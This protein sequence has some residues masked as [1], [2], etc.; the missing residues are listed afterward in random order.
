[1]FIKTILLFITVLMYF[2]QILN[3]FQMKNYVKFV[4]ILSLNEDIVN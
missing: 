2:I 1:M 4:K 3:Y